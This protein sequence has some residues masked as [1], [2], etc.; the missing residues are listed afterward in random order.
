MRRKKMVV[1]LGVYLP[2]VLQQKLSER[3]GDIEV[4]N[5][6]WNHQPD[7]NLDNL[8]ADAMTRIRAKKSP[9]DVM[10][11]P[12]TFTLAVCLCMSLCQ[13]IPKPPEIVVVER[14]GNNFLLTNLDPVAILARSDPNFAGS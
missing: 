9:V 7:K 8:M 1:V 12:R 5:F 13:G 2:D 11:I 3:Y 10:V 14:K 6:L 4:M